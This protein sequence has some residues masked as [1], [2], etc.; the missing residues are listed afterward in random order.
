MRKSLF[1]CASLALFSCGDNLE[2]EEFSGNPIFPGWY[3]DPEAIIFDNE[4]WIYPTYSDHYGEPDVSTGL[5]QWQIDNQKNTTDD[6]FLM[7]TF[8]NAFSSKDLINW[9]KHSHVLDI[10]DVS[11][12]SFA[13]W[14]P[15]IM[16]AN[17]QYYLFFGANNVHEGEV[18]GIGVATSKSPAGPFKD[19]LG[20]P[21]INEIIN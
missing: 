11:W 2:T 9:Q 5:S 20:K 13:L 3:A 4:Y 19:A 1:I 8:M 18:G 17:G 16:K 10:K 21:L 6:G 12:A 7:Q 14:A 15:S